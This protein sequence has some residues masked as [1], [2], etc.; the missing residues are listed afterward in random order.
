MHTIVVSGLSVDVIRKDI[1]NLHLGV[2]PPEGKIRMSVPLSVN[3]E[4][5][6]LAVI[7]KLAWIKQQQTKFQSQVRQPPRQYEYRE[8]HY[9]LGQRYLLN[10]IEQ[11]GPSRVELQNKTRMNLYVPIGSGTAKREQI[12]LGWYRKELKA[13]LPPLIDKWEEILGVTVHDWGIKQMKTKWGSC[14]I[15]AKR[16]W[17]NLE[18]AKKSPQCIEYIVVHEMIHLKERHHNAHFKELMDRFLPQW[19]SIREELNQAPLRHET[20]EY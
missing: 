7:S 14:N 3:D 5:V 16:I 2:Y 19:R 13:I 20:W 12:L 8:S 15:K 4:A 1:K 17:I 9:F 18:L 6:R 10:V 11:K